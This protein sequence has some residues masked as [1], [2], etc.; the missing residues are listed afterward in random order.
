MSTKG[1]ILATSLTTSRFVSGDK[2]KKDLWEEL[3]STKFILGFF[4]GNNLP[5]VPVSV[6]LRASPSKAQ[7]HFFFAASLVVSAPDWSPVYQPILT[8]Y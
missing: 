6:D 7:S 1:Q 5:E 8:S 2:Q 3:V 4:G